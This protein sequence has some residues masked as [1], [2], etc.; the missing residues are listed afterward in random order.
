MIYFLEGLILYIRH[1]TAVACLDLILRK[2]Y[3]FYLCRFILNKTCRDAS[4]KLNN[5]NRLIC[6]ILALSGYYSWFWQFSNY[7]ERLKMRLQYCNMIYKRSSGLNTCSTDQNR[8][9]MLISDKKIKSFASHITDALAVFKFK[10][11]YLNPWSVS[12]A[13]RRQKKEDCI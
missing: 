6:D 13:L 5:K 8:R 10:C 1:T 2:L 9:T 3:L 7:L 11:T 12:V 4:S